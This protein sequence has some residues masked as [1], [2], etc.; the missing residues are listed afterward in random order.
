MAHTTLLE[1]SCTGS[2]D[3]FHFVAYIFFCSK[4]N[5]LVNRDLS[6]RL[7]VWSAKQKGPLTVVMG[8]SVSL[9][10]ILLKIKVY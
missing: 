1:I 3:N 9:P 7:L 5:S 6:V 2:N 10:I 8:I 4:T